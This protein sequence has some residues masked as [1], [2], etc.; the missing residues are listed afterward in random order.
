[1]LLTGALSLKREITPLFGV[2]FVVGSWI[3]SDIFT[4]LV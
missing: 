2:G 1:M 3:S 4:P